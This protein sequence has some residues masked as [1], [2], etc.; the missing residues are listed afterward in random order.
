MV[1]Y[2]KFV[3]GSPLYTDPPSNAS[4]DEGVA[5]RVVKQ[6]YG[7]PS[8]GRRIRPVRREGSLP[9]ATRPAGKSLHPNNQMALIFV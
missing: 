9:G 8:L 6:P 1:A 2:S 3:I 7:R 4:L 5:H